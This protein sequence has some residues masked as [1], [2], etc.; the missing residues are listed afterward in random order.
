M[1]L[2][3]LKSHGGNSVASHDDH[4]DIMADEKVRIL[5]C[6]LTDDLGRFW[7]VRY[8]RRITEINYIFVRQ[9]L[10]QGLHDRQSTDPRIEHT[11]GLRLLRLGTH[12]LREI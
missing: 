2:D 1:F 3:N 5:R 9:P 12:T 7:S 11:D 4:L 6:I 8:T 10:H